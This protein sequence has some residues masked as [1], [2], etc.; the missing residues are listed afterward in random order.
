MGFC[1]HAIPI[2]Q[3]LADKVNFRL[4]KGNNETR[5]FLVPTQQVP[6]AP[7][8]SKAPKAIADLSHMEDR[9][10]VRK[11][12][13]LCRKKVV[14]PAPATSQR[15]EFESYGIGRCH[16]DTGKDDQASLHL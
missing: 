11:F 13:G 2:V 15:P 5:T 8:A 4:V 3:R 12:S 7:H 14:G 16:H 1:K 10:T 9:P 6:G